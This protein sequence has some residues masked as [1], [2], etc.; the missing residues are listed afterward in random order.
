MTLDILLIT[1]GMAINPG[2][3][4]E[5]ENIL[6]V[7]CSGCNRNLKSGTQCKM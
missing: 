3:G 5:A 2:L 4:V 7:L 1:G 6:Q